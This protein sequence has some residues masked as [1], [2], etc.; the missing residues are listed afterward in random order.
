MNSKKLNLK[1]LFFFIIIFLVVQILGLVV[2]NYY[3]S[4]QLVTGV[5]NE[6]PNSLVNVIFMIAY[7]L[8]FTFLLLFFKK[9]IKKNKILYILEYLV[10]FSAISIVLDVFVPTIISYFIAIYLLIIKSILRKYNKISIYYNN[11]LLALALSGAG[12]ILGLSLGIIPVMFFITLLSIYDI[13]SVFYTKHMLALAN[14]FIEQ[15]INLLFTIPTKKRTYRLGGGDIVIPLLVSSSLYNILIKQYSLLIT[16]IPI[17]FIWLSSIF[18]LMWVFWILK[19]EK[20]KAMPALPPQVFLMIIVL[21]I[22]F[23]IL[24]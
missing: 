4:Q 21:F 1:F 24:L 12:S 9:F 14:M 11:F 6:D 23:F 15:K 2:S 3:I 18:G 20:A 5:I 19:Q 13:I 22:T 16:L 8:F 7:I 10:L 17:F